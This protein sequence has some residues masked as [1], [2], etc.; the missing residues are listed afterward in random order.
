MVSHSAQ[1]STFIRMLESLELGSRNN[2]AFACNPYLVKSLKGVKV[3]ADG[4]KSNLLFLG[5]VI[6]VS[7]C[8]QYEMGPEYFTS[9]ILSSYHYHLWGQNYSME[10]KG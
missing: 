7:Y 1:Y 8:A 9:M 3:S 5:R 10:K 2:A 6:S 4:T